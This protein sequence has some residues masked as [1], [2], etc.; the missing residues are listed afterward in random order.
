[1]RAD[2]VLSQNRMHLTEERGRWTA[3]QAVSLAHAGLGGLG[4]KPKWRVL[5]D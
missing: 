5:T 2:I 1:M 4:V 3:F